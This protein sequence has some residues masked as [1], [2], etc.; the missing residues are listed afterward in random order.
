[1]LTQWPVGGLILHPGATNFT[2]S[3]HFAKSNEL[4][5]EEPPKLRGSVRRVDTLT[6]PG[7]VGGFL[8][9]PLF[10]NSSMGKGTSDAAGGKVVVYG[11]SS[12]LDTQSHPDFLPERNKGCLTLLHMFLDFI[13]TGTVVDPG[14][15]QGLSQDPRH[16]IVERVSKQFTQLPKRRQQLNQ[17]EYRQMSLIKEEFRR[18]VYIPNYFVLLSNKYFP[19]CRYSKVEQ[20]N[21]ESEYIGDTFR[22]KYCDVL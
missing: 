3:L 17:R 13:Q 14:G 6:T 22:K 15:T 12:C 18:F 7:Y 10:Q 1:M 5:E 8:N 11:D 20:L 21:Q 4:K 16:G 19:T 2:L 9:I